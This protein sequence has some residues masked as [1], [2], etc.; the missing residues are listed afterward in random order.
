MVKEKVDKKAGMKSYLWFLMPVFIL[1]ITLVLFRTVFLIGYVPSESMEPTLKKDSFIIG[2]R[3]YG[4]IEVGD[5]VI[6][7]HEGEVMVKRVAACA[8]D[9]ITI[10]EQSWTVP[11]D[12]YF[13]LGDNSYNSFDSRYWV[14]PFVEES[15]IVAKSF[16][17]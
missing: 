16:M 10:A 15:E 3:L 13:V 4:D 9:T 11:A 8:G 7:E 5:V 6:F 2:Y 17:K 12:S 14:D 1:I